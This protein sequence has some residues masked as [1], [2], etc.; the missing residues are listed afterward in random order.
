[1]ARDR[2]SMTIGNGKMN[3]HSHPIDILDEN[4][5]R[6]EDLPALCIREQGSWREM[7]YGQMSRWSR[8]LASYLMESGLRK[9]DRVAILSENRPEWG[10]AFFAAV[11]AGATVVPLDTQ[12]SVKELAHIVGN[13]APRVL[14][15]SAG[16]QKIARKLQ[17]KVGS[18]Y[19]LQPGDN[20]TPSIYELVPKHD[21][22]SRRRP[23]DE[24]ALIMYT[25][26]TTRKPK[27]VMITYKNLAFQV[28]SQAEN[29]DVGAG[30]RVL[31]ILPLNHLLELTC[32]F[33]GVLQRGG[34]ICFAN[35]LLA[36]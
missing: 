12:L 33:L 27:A 31:S 22:S 29:I 20:G 35:T 4:A 23:V 3:G 7:T 15:V 24:A 5:R 19:N 21:L 18:V 9:G 25:S 17:D 11:C 10:I 36:P 8:W 13:C 6:F 30:D 26:D 14:F 34:T 32:G 28:R 2:S 16:Y 1:M